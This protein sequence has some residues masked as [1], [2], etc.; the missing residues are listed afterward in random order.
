MPELTAEAWDDFLS[1]HPEAHLLQTAGWGELKAAFGWDV[2]R[3]T[4]G[5]CGAQVL[6]RRLPLGLT[7][8]YLPKGPVGD[9]TPE[10]WDA[11]DRLCRTRRAAFLK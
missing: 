9:P 2:A 6:F 4:L 7:M 1:R 10:F 5:D 8:A 11:L 3:L